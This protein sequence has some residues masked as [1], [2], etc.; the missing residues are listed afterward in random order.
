MA[1]SIDKDISSAEMTAYW[2][3]LESDLSFDTLSQLMITPE[4]QQKAINYQQSQFNAAPRTFCLRARYFYDEAL[5]LLNTNHYNSLISLGSGFSL[6]TYLIAKTY[7]QKHPD[8][9]LNIIDTDLE[10]II[11]ARKEK[12]DHIDL[13]FNL[14]YQHFIA[15]IEQAHQNNTPLADLFSTAATSP[16]FLIEGLSYFLSIDCLTWLFTSIQEQYEN[17]AIIWDYWSSDLPQRSAFFVRLLEY[18]KNAL[19]N[20][21]NGRSVISPEFLQQLTQGYHYNKLSLSDLEKKL[22][23]I[24]KHI[25]LDENQFIPIDFGVFVKKN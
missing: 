3:S 10:K 7:L 19:P 13:G 5:Q 9:K 16:I 21:E 17:A 12:L 14:D 18:F 2:R 20:N 25:L 23:P 8:K 15:D 11:N 24:E 1:N 6:L 4:G 22:L